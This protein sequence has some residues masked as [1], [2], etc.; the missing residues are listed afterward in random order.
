MI[1]TGAQNPWTGA[2]QAIKL[3]NGHLESVDVPTAEADLHLPNTTVYPGFINTH[4]H[5]EFNLFPAI[6]NK[7]YSDWIDWGAE[8]HVHFKDLIQQITKVPF[9]TRVAIGQLKCL[10]N[11]I[12]T[13]I[14]HGPEQIPSTDWLSIWQNYHYLHTVQKYIQRPY[15]SLFWSK[16]KPLMVHLAEGVTTR[17]TKEFSQISRLNIRRAPII[18]IHGIALTPQQAGRLHALIWCPDSNQFMYEAHADVEALANTTT[19][20]FGTDSTV[21]SQWSWFAQLRSALEYGPWNAEELLGI[22]YDHPTKIFPDFSNLGSLKP[23][24][25][26]DLVFMEGTHSKPGLHLIQGNAK[27]ILLVVKRGRVAMMDDRIA[28]QLPPTLKGNMVLVSVEGTNKWIP[29]TFSE[30]LSSVNH[31]KPIVPHLPTLA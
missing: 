17:V 1:I 8:V 28:N 15:Q 26:A 14:H 18:G 2:P 30:A 13:V 21:T 11:G 23:G 3:V 5:L 31:L 22:L 19:I 6:K 12:T 24:K 10:L 20:L 16:D 4:D 29:N 27:D 25:A 7:T 9:N